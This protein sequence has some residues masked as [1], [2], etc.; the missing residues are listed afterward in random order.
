MSELD[1]IIAKKASRN[2]VIISDVDGVHTTRSGGVKIGQRLS[3]SGLVFEVVDNLEVL[4]LVPKDQ[5]KYPV[6]A[7]FAGRIG[8]SVS[9]YYR[10]FT[11]DGQGVQSLLKVGV[12]VLITSGRDAAPVRHRFGSTLKYVDGENIVRPE[13]HLGVKDKLSHFT[14]REMDFNRVIFV[15]DGLQDASL[16]LAVRDAGGIAVATADAEP[17]AVEAAGVLTLSKGGE[18]AFAEVAHAYLNF[19]CRDNR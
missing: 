13:L 16:L 18:G 17:E 12:R 15:A 4:E 5:D 1:E 8:E 7:V 3:D 6:E 19:L 10:F 14:Q 2:M 11:P 9:E